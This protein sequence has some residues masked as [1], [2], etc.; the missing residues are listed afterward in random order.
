M[1]MND[2]ERDAWLREA[3]RHAPDS[4]VLPPRELSEAI[5]ASA[6]AAAQSAQATPSPQVRPQ[7]R[8]SRARPTHRL[9]AF[10][11]WLARPAVAAG[12]ASVLAATLIGLMW[13]DRPMDEMLA[14]RLPATR[15]EAAPP[16]AGADV[17]SAQAPTPSTTGAP[18]DALEERRQ[19]QSTPARAPGAR[20][21]KVAPS[22]SATETLKP[23]AERPAEAPR[24]QSEAKK[25]EVPA[26]FPRDELQRAAPA[27]PA[28]RSTGE[29]D[30][31]RNAADARR[32]AE[33]SRKDRVAPSDAVA[34]APAARGDAPAPAAAP[35]AKSIARVPAPV[36]PATP[37]PTGTAAPA[38]PFAGGPLESDGQRG[39]APTN[40]E[41]DQAKRAAAQPALGKHSADEASTKEARAFASSQPA[42]QRNALAAAPRE[43]AAAAAPLAPVLAGIAADPAQWSRQSASG[44]VVALDPEWRDW[45]LQLDAAATGRGRAVGA[46]NATPAGERARNAGVTVRLIGRDSAPVV[47]RLED[48]SASVEGAAG[49]RWQASL[50]PEAAERLRASA[51]RLAP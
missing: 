5:L 43:G 9:A 38:P 27:A 10:W 19:Q 47:V 11:D 33:S 42:A 17:P 13:W 12:F 15:D 31:Q 1:A 49:E 2:D 45:L 22:T 25:Q 23:S 29:K 40:T 46:S 7:R 18:A 8:A 36:A 3:L 26:A 21:A 24:Q 41:P 6:R 30:A 44:A 16:A 50:P 28:P 20:D 14:P 39:A 32:E 48:G 4:G 51:E 37:A 34:T 35:A